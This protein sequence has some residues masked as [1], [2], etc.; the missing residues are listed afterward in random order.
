MELGLS[1]TLP[2]PF[3]PNT[4]R[5]GFSLFPLG[6]DGEPHGEV[7]RQARYTLET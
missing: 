2:C 4:L 5:A 3:P 6:S 7:L 1:A